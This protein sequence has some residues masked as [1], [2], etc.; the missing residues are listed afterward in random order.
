[1]DFVANIKTAIISRDITKVRENFIKAFNA[2]IEMEEIISKNNLVSLVIQSG[3]DLDMLK[4]LI[5]NY[6]NPNFPLNTED[7]KLVPIFLLIENLRTGKFNDILTPED[8]VEQAKLL[9]NTGAKLYRLSETGKT[10]LKTIESMS[11]SDQQIDGMNQIKDVLE[12]YQELDKE[13]DDLNDV[14]YNAFE[15]DDEQDLFNFLLD[16][17]GMM[18]QHPKLFKIYDNGVQRLIDIID[19]DEWGILNFSKLHEVIAYLNGADDTLIRDSNSFLGINALMKF[20]QNFGT[21]LTNEDAIKTYRLLIDNIDIN[22]RDF[23][24]LTAL[25]YALKSREKSRKY[26]PDNAKRGYELGPITDPKSFYFG[27]FPPHLQSQL[28]SSENSSPSDSTQTPWDAPL[29]TMGSLDD[30]D[31]TLPDDPE[32]LKDELYKALGI[33]VDYSDHE[34]VSKV[35][36]RLK[37]IFNKDPS[38]V[39]YSNKKENIDPPIFWMVWIDHDSAEQSKQVKPFLEL[40]KLFNVNLLQTNLN[41]QTIVEYCIENELYF[42]LKN[43]NDVFNSNNLF[44]KDPKD[45]HS[46]NNMFD[47]AYETYQTKL[48]KGG[49]VNSIKQILQLI[50]YMLLNA[51]LLNPSPDNYKLLPDSKKYNIKILDLNMKYFWGEQSKDSNPVTPLQIVSSGWVGI[52][53]VNGDKITEYLVKGGADAS[54]PVLIKVVVYKRIPFKD[55]SQSEPN[56][57]TTKG[58]QPSPGIVRALLQAG[59]FPDMT[60]LSKMIDVLKEAEKIP[61]NETVKPQIRE[62]LNLILQA[63]AINILL[64]SPTVDPVTFQDRK[65]LLKNLIEEHPEAFDNYSS[66]PL[67]EG[68]KPQTI[69]PEGE[70]FDIIM[71]GSEKISEF[72]QEDRENHIVLKNYNAADSE[73]YLVDLTHIKNAIGMDEAILQQIEKLKD[74]YKG[75]VA[76]LFKA[77]DFIQIVYQQLSKFAEDNLNSVF[78][79]ID[80]KM[81]MI[82]RHAKENLDEKISNIGGEGGQGIILPCNGFAGGNFN[83]TSNMVNNMEPYFNLRNI[84]LAVGVVPLLEL[85]SKI[86][87]HPVEKRGQY[88]SYKVSKEEVNPFAGIGIVNYNNTGLNRYGGEINVVSASHCEAGDNAQIVSILKAEEEKSSSVGGKR[89]IKRESVKKKIRKAKRTRKHIKK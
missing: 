88:F 55:D 56:V 25:D 64:I 32:K 8:F 12:E 37:Q 83:I 49:S 65:I 28:S 69:N 29:P 6:T 2:N 67:P 79:D 73:P 24:G 76:N 39:N 17:Q 44:S 36:D 26:F 40:L 80:T 52:V 82:E 84:G 46:V 41:G 85:Y 60:E 77:D 13:R 5:F 71:Q 16:I 23:F 1:M 20:I 10:P 47:Y 18:Y 43:L 86:L 53:I 57:L 81:S 89:K 14:I 63:Y 35:L 48:A 7:T 75:M 51:V 87:I 34:K 62:I 30:I 22:Q 72:L 58:V 3:G 45:K 21:G 61:Q 4:L 54:D 15:T 27:T 42:L 9:A 50:F 66:P 74:I 59:G 70:G 78:S 38:L 19:I 68:I 11:E 33:Y 31:D